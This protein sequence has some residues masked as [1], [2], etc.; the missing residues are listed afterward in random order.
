MGIGGN[1][2]NLLWE[3]AG[4]VRDSIGVSEIDES[5]FRSCQDWSNF[6]RKLL[7]LVRI[8]SEVGGNRRKN[9]PEHIS[10]S[11]FVIFKLNPKSLRVQRSGICM[12]GW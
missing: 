10:K 11:R 7:G 6:L 9:G 5:F 1:F 3:W 12:L 8:P 4:L 2:S